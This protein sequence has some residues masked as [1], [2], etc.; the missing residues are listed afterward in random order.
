MSNPS[1]C[2]VGSD[3]QSEVSPRRASILKNSKRRIPD[4]KIGMIPLFG[5]R[6]LESSIPQLVVR[7]R[8]VRGIPW[9]RPEAV[10]PMWQHRQNLTRAALRL[11]ELGLLRRPVSHAE[12]RCFESSARLDLRIEATF[13]NAADE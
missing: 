4:S 13:E 5:I 7:P 9:K 3:A 10:P 1:G 12:V 2:Q 11:T 8:C 6:N